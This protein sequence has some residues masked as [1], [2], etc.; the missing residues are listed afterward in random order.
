MSLKAS[1]YEP[2]N[3]AG[4]VSGTNFVVCSYGKLQPGYRDEIVYV[5]LN[6]GVKFNEQAYSVFENISRVFFAEIVKNLVSLLLLTTRGHSGS[7]KSK[8]KAEIIVILVL[9]YRKRIRI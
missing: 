1:S 2:G 5:I 3:R 9:L 7:R 8:K 4:S 6:P